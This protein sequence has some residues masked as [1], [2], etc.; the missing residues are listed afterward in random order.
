[1]HSCLLVF[2]VSMEFRGP[3][4]PVRRKSQRRIQHLTIALLDPRFIPRYHPSGGR[5]DVSFFDITAHRAMRVDPRTPIDQDD[6]DAPH[7]VPFTGRACL[8]SHILRPHR[9]RRARPRRFFS[10]LFLLSLVHSRP[11]RHIDVLS[12]ITAHRALRVDPRT[13]IDQDDGDAQHSGSCS[14]RACLGSHILRPHRRRGFRCHVHK[15][16]SDFFSI[17]STQP[18]VLF[19]FVLFCF[20]RVHFCVFQPRVH[21]REGDGSHTWPFLF[22]VGRPLGRDGGRY[23]TCLLGL[24]L[25]AAL[26]PSPLYS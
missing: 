2:S 1:M 15:S 26:D 17:F 13:P 23:A 7:S 4:D 24:G 19:C 5:F 12:N 6:G 3:R 22:G 16:R 25:V 8:G 21:S 10:F 14:G 18:F 9:R 20:A 11:R